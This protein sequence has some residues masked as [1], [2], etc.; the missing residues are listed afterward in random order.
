MHD[1]DLIFFLKIGGKFGFAELGQCIL[2]QV[3]PFMREEKLE[4][5][6]KVKGIEPSAHGT[7]EGY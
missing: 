4:R 5:H 1:S 2:Q 6:L 3:Y 7:T